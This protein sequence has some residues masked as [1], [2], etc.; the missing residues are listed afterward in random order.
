M[1]TICIFLKKCIVKV[2]ACQYINIAVSVSKFVIE[3]WT[4]YTVWQFMANVIDL[5][6]N[7]VPNIGN[8][9]RS[10]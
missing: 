4:L 6:T 3:K 1:Q 8:L 10:K 2:F 9:V 7:V 5:L